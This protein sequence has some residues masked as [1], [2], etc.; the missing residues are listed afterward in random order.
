MGCRDNA[1][2]EATS[3]NGI[4]YYCEKHKLFFAS[5]ENLKMEYKKLE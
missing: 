5:N 3:S 2:W 4:F 1:T